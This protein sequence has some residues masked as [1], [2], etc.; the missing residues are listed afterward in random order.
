MQNILCYGDSNTWGSSLEGHDDGRY[1]L[2][3]RWTSILQNILGSD[4]YRIIEEGLGG[5]TTVS[6]DPIEGDW[7]N[8][9]TPLLAILHSHQPLDWVIIMLGTNDL[10]TRFG[11]NAHEIALGAKVLVDIVKDQD[12]GTGGKKPEILLICP[13]HILDECAEPMEIFS[14]AEVISKEMPQ[15]YAQFADEAGVHFLNA[16]LHIKTSDIDGI[17][18]ASAEHKK[19]AEAIAEIVK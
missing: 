4:N 13:P 15:H 8:G 1:P 14:N 3:V 11:K 5:R 7:K 2:G 16:G 10:K 9:R 18:W 17:H 12:I 19:L 6:D